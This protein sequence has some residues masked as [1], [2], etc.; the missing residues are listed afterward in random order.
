MSTHVVA[1][2]PAPG[3]L[4]LVTAAH[5]AF[6]AAFLVVAVVHAVR[7]GGME[8]A[9]DPKDWIPFGGHLLNPFTWLYAVL[10]LLYLTG[11]VLS[12]ALLLVS[13]PL[14][15]RRWSGSRPGVRWLLVVGM[16]TAV[17]LPLL[18]MTAFGDEL[19]RWWLD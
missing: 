2:Q 4:R 7:T 17:A 9:S 19:S 18:R 8:G 11:P 13:V 14:L 3:S 15:A 6:A 5:L 16:V 12:P 10:S 1:R